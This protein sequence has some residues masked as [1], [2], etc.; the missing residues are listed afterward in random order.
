MTTD[1]KIIA[2]ADKLYTITN[3]PD[4]APELEMIDRVTAFLVTLPAL[5]LTVCF[6][7]NTACF[8][9]PLSAL[10]ARIALTAYSHCM[11]SSVLII[12]TLTAP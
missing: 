1:P 6:P 2:L 7:G 11:Y 3:W 8:H 5:M 9:C 10:I 4:V 12:Y